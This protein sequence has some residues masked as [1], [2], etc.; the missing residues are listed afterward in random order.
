MENQNNSTNA[1]NTQLPKPSPQPVNSS[2]SRKKW[3]LVALA[4]ISISIA[5]LIVVVLSAQQKKS[6]EVGSDSR[7]YTGVKRDPKTMHFISKTN[8]EKIQAAISNAPNLTE[9]GNNTTQAF[10]QAMKED[11]GV[12]SSYNAPPIVVDDS[13]K[14]SVESYL[15]GATITSLEESDLSIA[16]KMVG[17]FADEYAKYPIEWMRYASSPEAFV[18]AKDVGI[19]EDSAGGVTRVAIVYDA[20]LF[21]DIS[22][23]V[24][25]EYANAYLKQLIH[26]EIAHWI[27]QQS[28]VALDNTY[29]RD[30]VKINPKGVSAYN[31]GYDLSSGDNYADHPSLGFITGYAMTNWEED[32][33]EVY[34]YMFTKEG[35]KMLDKY[36]AKDPILKKKVDYWKKFIQ[37]K[38]PG[39][40]DSYFKKYIEES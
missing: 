32:K 40:D 8:K 24:E 17:L 12:Y 13:L 25:E 33:A 22:T 3:I 10:E 30:W 11:Y 29:D 31:S 28:F 20:D 35:I 9:L 38:V 1:N 18:F 14:T 2:S 5:I 26:H 15:E 36:S 23:P 34:C 16:K 27:D 7:P 19:G 4:L 37:K 39:M 21:R 6:Q